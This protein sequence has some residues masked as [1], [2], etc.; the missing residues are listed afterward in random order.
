MAYKRDDPTEKGN[1]CVTL[2]SH[3]KL[4]GTGVMESSFN[5]I[6]RTVAA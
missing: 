4:P 2:V 3:G 5:N 6:S 1:S